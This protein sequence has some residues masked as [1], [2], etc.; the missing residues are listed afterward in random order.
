MPQVKSLAYKKK[1]DILLEYK[2]VLVPNVVSC[3][4]VVSLK[5]EN[6]PSKSLKFN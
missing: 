4:I 2:G 6:F 3:I 1:N 5:L